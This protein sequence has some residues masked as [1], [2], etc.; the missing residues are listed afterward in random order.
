MFETG[1]THAVTTLITEGKS[2]NIILGGF[3]NGVIKLFDL[4]SHRKTAVVK[5]D[6]DQ[7]GAHDVMGGTGV[8]KL[9]VFL[10][11]SR[12]ITA[13]WL[14]RIGAHGQCVGSD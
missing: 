9:G 5:I 7:P 8:K 14:V 12:T 1:E 2:G 13:A 10:G 4:R 11:E 3:D 6:G